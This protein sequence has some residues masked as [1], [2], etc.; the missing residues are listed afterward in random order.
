MVRTRADS[1]TKQAR[2]NDYR[3]FEKAKAS[4]AQVISTDYYYP[5]QLFESTYQVSFENGKF[6]RIK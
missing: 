2:A 3:Q 5:S 6:E 4:G 1:D